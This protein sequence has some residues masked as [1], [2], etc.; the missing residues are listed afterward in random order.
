[1]PRLRGR[2]KKPAEPLREGDRGFCRPSGLDP[3]IRGC[4]GTRPSNGLM[5]T[6]MTTANID[7]QGPG[8]ADRNKAFVRASTYAKVRPCE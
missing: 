6:S 1:M 5:E 8:I 7:A 2:G 4:V 3:S